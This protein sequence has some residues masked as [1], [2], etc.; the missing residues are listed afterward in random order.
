[1]RLIRQDRQDFLREYSGSA[2][3]SSPAA[4]GVRSATVE[5]IRGWFL[6]RYMRRQDA[7]LVQNVDKFMA[8]LIVERD[9]ENPN[10][11]NVLYPPQLTGWLAVMAGRVAFRLV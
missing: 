9:E 7:A 10:Q 1:M 6:A 3:A 5:Q 8:E 4:P 11:I 2:L